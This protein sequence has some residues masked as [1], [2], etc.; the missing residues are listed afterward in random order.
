MDELVYEREIGDGVITLSSNYRVREY[1]R[2]SSNANVGVLIIGTLY[3]STLFVCMALAILSVKTLS[4][5]DEEK[6]AL[7]CSTV[8]AQTS[9]RGDPRCF[10]RSEYSSLCPLRCRSC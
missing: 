3:V 4:T 9:G 6:S 5:L 2:Q 1:I 10:V 8:S 7:T